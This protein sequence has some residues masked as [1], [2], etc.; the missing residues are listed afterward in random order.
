MLVREE[1]QTMATITLQNYFRLYDKLSGMTGTAKTEDAEFPRHLQASVE[2]IPVNQ[3]VIRE[4]AADLVYRTVDAKVQRRGR[5]CRRAPCAPAALPGRHRLHRKLRGLPSLLYKRGIKHS[6]LNAKFHEQEANIVA[7]AGRA[8]R[9]HH[10][11]Q[12]GR[13]WYR[14]PARWQ[15]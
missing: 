3:P 5:R 8:G 15:P 11:H 10:R 14:H 4:D 7:Q 6:V 9:C 1:N 2:V 13:P 12:H